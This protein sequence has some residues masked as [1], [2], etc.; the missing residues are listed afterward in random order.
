MSRPRVLVV[1][2]N[3]D[4]LEYARAVLCEAY[5]LDLAVSGAAALA[6]ARSR[7]PALVVLDISLPDRDGW[8]I[9]GELRRDPTTAH[10][11]VV[12]CTAHAL[13][14]ER[15][16]TLQAGFDAYLSKPYRAREL[17]ELVRSFVGEGQPGPEGER[18]ELAPDPQEEPA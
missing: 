14:G 18:W 5:D 7:P 11:P 4:N 2:D 13:G 9:L 8:S 16:R 3:P 17:L 12:A 15:E 1:D 10:L 6:L